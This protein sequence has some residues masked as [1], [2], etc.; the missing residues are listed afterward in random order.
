LQARHAGL[1]GDDLVERD[2]IPI[3]APGQAFSVEFQSPRHHNDAT[4]W[5]G[6]HVLMFNGDRDGYLNWMPR[7]KAEPEFTGT[8]RFPT[9]FA[10]IAV[11][12]FG[13]RPLIAGKRA[14]GEHDV[15]LV[16]SRD[17]IPPELEAAL[18]QPLVNAA[19]EPT[20][21][22]L[23]IWLA[24]RMAKEV[25]EADI[26]RGP[27]FVGWPDDPGAISVRASS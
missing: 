2:N 26:V 19:L 10:S 12:R 4:A 20:L 22:L 1:P 17:P 15:I 25:P 13:S 27:F 14:W 9:G 16:V 24:D 11:P 8:D 5:A 21:N 23:A 7:Y 3:V 18:E 6:W